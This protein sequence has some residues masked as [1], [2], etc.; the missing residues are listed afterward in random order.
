ME[1]ARYFFRNNR[2]TVLLWRGIIPSIQHRIILA[3][4]VIVQGSLFFETFGTKGVG[5]VCSEKLV[6]S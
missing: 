4:I 1:N 6:V 3:S 2:L 5:F